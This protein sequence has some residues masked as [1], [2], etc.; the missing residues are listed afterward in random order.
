MDLDCGGGDAYADV[1]APRYLLVGS[2]G[3]DRSIALYDIS[4]H[5]S[6]ARVH[7]RVGGSRIP[8]TSSS[9]ATTTHRPMARSVIGHR[10]YR[11]GGRRRRGDGN[12]GEYDIDGI[13]DI[14]DDACDVP[15]GH[16]HP[17]LGV[18][19][20]PGEQRFF[21]RNIRHSSRQRASFHKHIMNAPPLRPEKK[22]QKSQSRLR[23]LRLGVHV[24]GGTRV[25]CA[26]L[27]S[28]VRDVQSRPCR[29][30]INGGGT[31]RV[32]LVR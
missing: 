11:A 14:D 13:N 15:S 28:R 4:R 9:A 21:L 1:D 8:S 16:R 30:R 25:G 31:D 27:R 26:Q 10:R 24:G 17:I 22:K 20:Y 3:Y 23:F 6:D 5:G 18:H 29:R 7:H 32:V 12:D 19:W 2:G